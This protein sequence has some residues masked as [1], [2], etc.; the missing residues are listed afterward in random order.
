MA[1]AHENWGGDPGPIP[2][3]LM[4]EP[5]EQDAAV[6]AI[7]AAFGFAD[8]SEVPLHQ[9]IEMLAD[10]EPESWRITSDDEAE[11]AGRH[12]ATATAELEALRARAH[13]WQERIQHWFEQA[14]REPARAAEFFGSHLEWY[15]RRVR[16]ESERKSVA[17]PSVKITTRSS[18]AAAEVADEPAVAEWALGIWDEGGSIAPPQPRKVYVGELRKLTKV[19][20]VIDWARL[21]LASAEVVEWVRS[22][23]QFGTPGGGLEGAALDA[24]VGEV[25]P[26]VGDGWPNPEEATDLVAVVEALATHLEVHTL[27]DDQLVPGVIVRPES[28]SV[29]VSPV[30]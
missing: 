23:C 10:A 29:T 6:A 30:Q 24:V 5:V 20:E 27:A 11:W 15:G 3:E 22:G 13:A 19:V 18:P 26:Q 7:E 9:A 8:T 17:L 4:D 2:P 14:A 25:C 16:A 12:L 21:V 1:L 28:V